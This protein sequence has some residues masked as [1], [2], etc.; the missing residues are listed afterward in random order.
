V[1]ARISEKVHEHAMKIQPT[2]TASRL[3]LRRPSHCG[4]TCSASRPGLK[5]VVCYLETLVGLFRA[6]LGSYIRH[7]NTEV[8]WYHHRPLEF[9]FHE[10]S[11][12]TV[13]PE[14][15]GL[16]FCCSSNAFDHAGCDLISVRELS[17]KPKQLCRNRR[18][19]NGVIIFAEC[20]RFDLQ[21]FFCCW[22]E[23]VFRSR[24]QIGRFLLLPLMPCRFHRLQKPVSHIHRSKRQ[25]GTS[26]VSQAIVASEALSL[27]PKEQRISPRGL[28][29]IVQCTCSSLVR[30]HICSVDHNWLFKPYI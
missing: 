17:W 3:Y 18:D 13:N 28:T 14:I 5:L 21:N 26:G 2:K 25:D 9:D 24:H 30:L 20:I 19:M 8:Q 27:A 1:K 12:L 11:P 29:R 4:L 7:L 10:R 22:F 16:G 15:F 23:S 6:I